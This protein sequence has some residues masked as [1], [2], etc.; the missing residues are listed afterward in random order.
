LEVIED[1][2]KAFTLLLKV[3]GGFAEIRY[4]LVLLLALVLLVLQLPL[5]DGVFG[6]RFLELLVQPVHRNGMALLHPLEC[7]LELRSICMAEFCQLGIWLNK[8]KGKTNESITAILKLLL[9]V[10]HKSAFCC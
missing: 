9:Q 3:S 6:Q 2:V 1:L 4:L 8:A 7:G 5:E 10:R